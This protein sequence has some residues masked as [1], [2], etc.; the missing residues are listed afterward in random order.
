MKTI[1]KFTLLLFLSIQTYSQNID[2]NYYPAKKEHVSN[3]DFKIG[4]ENL[5]YAYA[6]I[7]ENPDRQLNYIDYWRVATAY[8]RLGED[9]ETIYKLLLKSKSSNKE[10]FCIILNYQ[11]EVNGGTSKDMRLYKILGKRYT[12]LLSGCSGIKLQLTKKLPVKNRKFTRLKYSKNKAKWN[13]FK[14]STTTNFPT[15]KEK[16]R[17]M[18]PCRLVNLPKKLKDSSQTHFRFENN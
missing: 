16:T 14:G 15:E 1:I 11:L 3:N 12:D 5:T 17:W 2:T 4:V 6:D 8:A 18:N 10:G 13:Y 7:N 9:K